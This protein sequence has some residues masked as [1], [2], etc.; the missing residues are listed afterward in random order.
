MKK[1]I[2]L[3]RISKGITIAYLS[4]AMLWCVMGCSCHIN[5]ERLKDKYRDGNISHEYYISKSMEFS[6]KEESIFK[7]IGIGFGLT[8]ISDVACEI[9]EFGKEH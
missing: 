1:H 7:A 9:V 5:R 2:N 8:F 4:T 6:K 3:R